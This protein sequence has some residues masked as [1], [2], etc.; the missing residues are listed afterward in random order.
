M[1]EMERKLFGYHRQSK[2]QEIQEHEFIP[3][4]S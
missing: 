2:E 4:K 3:I 1:E